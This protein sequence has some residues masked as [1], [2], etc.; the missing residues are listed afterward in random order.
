M[1]MVKSDFLSKLI[2]RF[3]GFSGVGAAVTLLSM[4]LIFVGNELLGIAPLISYAASYLITLFLSYWLNAK[5]VFHA[6]FRLR[7]L[8]WYVIAY[9]S[10][11]AVGMLLLKLLLLVVSG[12]ETIL[13]Y[14]V[15]PVT[16]VWNFLFA[17][18]IM[19]WCRRK[20]GTC[21]E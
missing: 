20:G 17:D 11:M 21:Y 2:V 1:T 12:Y 15:I 5:L 10:G 18:R 6:P 4:L 8:I 16:M 13:S 19:A 14:A 7:G 3:C 9:L